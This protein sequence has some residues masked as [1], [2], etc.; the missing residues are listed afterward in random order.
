MQLQGRKKERTSDLLGKK[1][2]F[3]HSRQSSVFGSLVSLLN[4]L[5]IY[6]IKSTTPLS[7]CGYSSSNA[8]IYGWWRFQLPKHRVVNRLHREGVWS[9]KSAT[10]DCCHFWQAEGLWRGFVQ[11]RF[12]HI[13]W[14]CSSWR[15]SRNTLFWA[16]ANYPQIMCTMGSN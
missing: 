10:L 7:H 5:L 2:Q 15:S 4:L 11:R 3:L 14:L 6:P 13:S 1:M 16:V 12:I 9:R 8:F